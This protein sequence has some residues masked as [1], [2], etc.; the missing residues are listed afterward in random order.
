MPKYS[1]ERKFEYAIQNKL[2]NLGWL[3]INC[4]RSKPFD[5]IAFPPKDSPI[6][7]QGPL[8]IELKGKDGQYPPEQHKMQ[9]QLSM[10]YGFVM[11]VIKQSKARGKRN[12]ELFFCGEQLALGFLDLYE[13]LETM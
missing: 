6:L 7:L 4:A 10:R 11:A 3:V 9:L 13:L 1:Q 5:L 12:V 8:L 2:K